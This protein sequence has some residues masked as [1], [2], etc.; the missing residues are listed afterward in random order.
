MR[1][2]VEQVFTNIS[3]HAFNSEGVA[4]EGEEDIEEEERRERGETREGRENREEDRMVGR[5]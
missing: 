2:H 4:Q 1:C 3:P 5:G